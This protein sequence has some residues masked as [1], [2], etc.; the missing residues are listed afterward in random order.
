M[1][2]DKIDLNSKFNDDYFD[3]KEII[4]VKE[5]NG[6]KNNNSNSDNTNNNN[7]KE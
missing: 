1:N 4:D 6:L 2:F 5:D 7:D 3:L